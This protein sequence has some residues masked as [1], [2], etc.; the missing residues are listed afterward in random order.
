MPVNATF[1]GTW[2]DVGVAEA[3]AESAPPTALTLML[4][5]E[6]AIFAGA[7]LSVTVRVAVQLHAEL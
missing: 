3:D 5:F 2:P 1:S 7:E 6:V 4:T